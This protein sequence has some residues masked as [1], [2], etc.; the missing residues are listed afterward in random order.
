MERRKKSFC[1][2]IEECDLD[3]LIEVGEGEG[4]GDGDGVDGREEVDAW[5]VG[6]KSSMAQLWK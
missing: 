1:D 2:R 3:G 4:D 6:R 5:D